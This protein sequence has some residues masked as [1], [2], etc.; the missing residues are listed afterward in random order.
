MVAYGLTLK[1]FCS[2][3][4]SLISGVGEKGRCSATLHIP[5]LP[6]LGAATPVLAFGWWGAALAAVVGSLPPPH[7]LQGHSPNP[8]SVSPGKREKRS[9]APA[10]SLESG[11]GPV[12]RN[13]LSNEV[14]LPTG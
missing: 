11:L 8:L 1:L 9:M 12:N 7:P 6:G 10:P 4:N 14:L 2:L 5:E 3:V 13:C